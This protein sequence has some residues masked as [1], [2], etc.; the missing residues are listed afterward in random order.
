MPH[1]TFKFRL[2][3]A[4]DAETSRAAI[5]ALNALC[6]EHLQDRHEIEIV[7]VFREPRR[8]LS[9][10][11]LMTPTLLKL[12]PAPVRRVVGTLANTELVLQALGLESLV[13]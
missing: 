10:G 3:V 11:I 2:Y 1:T 7:D 4:G 6:A 12:A 8:A 13:R 5:E 9:E